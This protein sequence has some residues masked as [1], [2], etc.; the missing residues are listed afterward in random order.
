MPV[1]RVSEPEKKRGVLPSELTLYS[2]G[3]DNFCKRYGGAAPGPFSDRGVLDRR[4]LAAQR[5]KLVLADT[6]TV[7]EGHAFTTGRI[8]RSGIERILPNTMVEFAVKDGLG[9]NMAHFSQAELQGKIMPSEMAK[10]QAAAA[11]DGAP[12]S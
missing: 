2:G 7:I 9:C 4:E 12:A 3:E 11:S 5:V 1:A 10:R 6:P 8:E